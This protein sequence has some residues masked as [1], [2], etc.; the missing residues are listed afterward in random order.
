[1]RIKRLKIDN[2]CGIKHFDG[3][4]EEQVI[5]LEDNFLRF[6]PYGSCISWAFNLIFH[7]AFDLSCIHETAEQVETVFNND[8]VI[9]C[10]LEEGNYNYKIVLFHDE[11]YENGHVFNRKIFI[12]GLLMPDD[13]TFAGSFFRQET[14]NF[15]FPR[16]KFSEHICLDNKRKGTLLGDNYID[17]I[18]RFKSD[19]EKEKNNLD[20]TSGDYC[21]KINEGRYTP[22][23]CDML[24][25][26]VNNF[27][28][29]FKPIEIQDGYILKINPNGMFEVTDSYGKQCS[30]FKNCKTIINAPV[31]IQIRI[32][33][34]V[35]IQWHLLMTQIDLH[36]KERVDLP[37]I[38]MPDMLGL[39]VNSSKDNLI[40]HF[41]KTGRQILLINNNEDSLLAKYCDQVFSIKQGT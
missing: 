26:F 14:M 11:H 16:Y 29:E 35:F 3:K 20:N 6:A 37:I 28:S 2:F 23:S 22:L 25:C 30:Q 31:D 10:E 34:L 24:L 33:L 12:D 39:D 4:F 27:I 40:E 8:S 7:F 41:R 1:M 32:Q 9:E 36:N 18:W 38:V 13:N 17:M 21:F 15:I 5:L 19:I